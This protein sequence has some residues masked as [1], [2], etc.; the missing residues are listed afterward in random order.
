MMID[1][2]DFAAARQTIEFQFQAQKHQ[3]IKTTKTSKQPKQPKH[4]NTKTPK[5]QNTK[6]PKHQ[7]N[8]QVTYDVVVRVCVCTHVCM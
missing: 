3:N 7:I 5:H 1:R 6:T 8:E 4:Q 2:R